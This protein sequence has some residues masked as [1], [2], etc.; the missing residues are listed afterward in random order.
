MPLTRHLRPGTIY[1]MESMDHVGKG[2]MFPGPQL[3]RL[4]Q[5]LRYFPF[6]TLITKGESVDSAIVSA[7]SYNDQNA[8][9]VVYAASNLSKF[10]Y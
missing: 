4:I 7:E 2:P 1:S 6:H 5:C 10:H 8:V 9:Q 3:F